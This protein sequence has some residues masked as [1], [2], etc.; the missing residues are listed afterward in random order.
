MKL[1]NDLD[2][3]LV[4]PNG[5]TIR[6]PY[7]GLT[8]GGSQTTVFTQTTANRRDNIEQAVVTSPATGQWKIRVRGFSLPDPNTPIGFVVV[9]SRPVSRDQVRYDDAL[10]AGTPV[11][12]TDNLP[13]GVARTFNVTETKLV[14][15]VRVYATCH[16]ARG[17]L[18]FV[19]AT[20]TTRKCCLRVMTPARATTSSASSPTRAD[21]DDVTTIYGANRPTAPGP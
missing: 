10:N 8:T 12:I 3:E 17:N 15:H 1:V 2:L 5:T 21:N 13:A 16:T 19:C 6:F 14:R 18:A 9:S 4:E 20:P 7:S 11:A